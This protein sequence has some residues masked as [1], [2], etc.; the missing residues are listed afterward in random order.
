MGVGG[1]RHASVALPR[2]R[3]GT[4]V[5]E[6]GWA[7]GESGQVRKMMPPQEFDP[8]TVEARSVWLNRS[9]VTG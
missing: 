5:Y 9:T 3:P 7:P 1:Q 6:A 4:I 8:R 2:E